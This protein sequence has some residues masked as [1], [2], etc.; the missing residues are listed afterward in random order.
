[1]GKMGGILDRKPAGERSDFKNHLVATFSEFV[2][3]FLFL[4]FAFC[5][6]QMAI[7]QADGTG[8]NGSNSSQTVIYISLG[9]GFSLLVTAWTMY[10]VSGGLFNPAITLGLM[11]TGNVPFVRG[12][13]YMPTQ[14]VAGMAAAGLTSAIIPGDIADVRTALG[15]F[16]SYLLRYWG[17]T[18]LQRPA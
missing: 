5:V 8:A 14:I 2:G 10:R 15:E 3:T 9:Y 17:L 1:M 12:L 4:F 7:A 13:Y 16:Q 6:Q 18:L 11:I